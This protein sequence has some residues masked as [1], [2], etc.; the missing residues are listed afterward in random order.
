MP[1]LTLPLFP[2]LCTAAS[3]R[4]LSRLLAGETLPIA[5]FDAEDAIAADRLIAADLAHV[6]GQ[7]LIA[8]ADIDAT[9]RRH[10]HQ[11]LPGVL[12]SHPRDCRLAS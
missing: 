5:S 4:M 12:L 1:A 6:R 8:A 10:V 11:W 3:S 9:L 2:E 7:R